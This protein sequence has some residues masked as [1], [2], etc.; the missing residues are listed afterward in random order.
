MQISRI[1]GGV[2]QN[3]LFTTTNMHLP[4]YTRNDVFLFPNIAENADRIDN[5]S[6]EKSCTARIS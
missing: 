4:G 3:P 2:S 5:V 6:K 1:F